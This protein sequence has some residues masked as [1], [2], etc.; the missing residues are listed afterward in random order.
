MLENGTTA[1]EVAKVILR[2]A[3]SSKEEHNLRYIIGSD[4][5]SVTEKRKSMT[6]KEFFNFMYKNILDT[7]YN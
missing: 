2:A 5:E 7:T 4:A 3:T 1:E 6:D